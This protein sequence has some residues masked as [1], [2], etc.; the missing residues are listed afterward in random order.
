[1]AG[2][3]AWPGFQWFGLVIAGIIVGMAALLGLLIAYYRLVHRRFGFILFRKGPRRLSI[4]SWNNARLLSRGQE[5]PWRADDWP[6]CERPFYASCR[7]GNRR[8]FILAGTIP[9]SPRFN[10]VEGVHP[11]HAPKGGQ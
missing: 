10:A 9:D 4:A 11:D 3:I 7:I 5:T 2:I 8:L 6:V 1:M